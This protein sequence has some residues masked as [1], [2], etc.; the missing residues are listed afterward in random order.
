MQYRP[1][2]KTGRSVSVLGFGGMR[3]SKDEELGA[4]AMLRAYE[5]GI[6]YFDTAPFYCRDRSLD[7]FG[8]ALPHMDREKILVSSKSNINHDRNEKDLQRSVEKMLKRMKIDTLDFLYMWCIFDLEQYRRIIA[9]GGPYEGARKLRREGIVR[10]IVFSAH[11]PT[12]DIVT[13]C[14]EGLFE[15]A[16]LSFNIINQAVR[17]EG[18]RAAHRSGIGTAVM[19]PLGGGLLTRLKGNL[20]I[21][22]GMDEELLRTALRFCASHEEV[23]CVLS[24]MKSPKEVEMNVRAIKSVEEPSSEEIRRVRQRFAGLGKN[25]CTICRY[26]LPCPEGIDIP[27]FMSAY[28]YTRAGLRELANQQIRFRQSKVTADACSECGECE[29]TCTQQLPIINRLKGK[30]PRIGK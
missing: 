19:N 2:G 4:A 10:H 6:N 25:F 13:I 17:L 12:S 11:A 23:G 27:A 20:D 24:G 29:E 7:I 14:E 9:P 22:R 1:Y 8:K 15:G 28:D 30:N 18:L 3:F 5:L 21:S 26:C 16:L